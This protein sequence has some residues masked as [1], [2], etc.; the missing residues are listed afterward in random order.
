MRWS[1][2]FSLSTFAFLFLITGYATP[3]E[4]MLALALCLAVIYPLTFIKGELRLV[5]RETRTLAVARDAA[6]G[7]RLGLVVGQLKEPQSGRIK[8]YKIKSEEGALIE[9]TVEAVVVEFQ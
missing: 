1:I 8:S 6:T 9:K 3:V 5:G 4:T 2:L 7:E